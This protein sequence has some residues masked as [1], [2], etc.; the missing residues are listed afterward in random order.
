MK[1]GKCS[2]QVC[3]AGTVPMLLAASNR[4]GISGPSA[5][6]LFGRIFCLLHCSISD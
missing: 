5:V 6:G 4:P 1:S 3:L 2:K